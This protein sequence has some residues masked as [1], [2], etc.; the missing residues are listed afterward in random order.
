MRPIDIEVMPQDSAAA[1]DA[2]AQALARLFTDAL[3]AGSPEAAEHLEEDSGSGSGAPAAADEAAAAAVAVAVAEEAV[4][5]A[6]SASNGD[7]DSEEASLARCYRLRA[8]IDQALGGLLGLTYNQASHPMGDPSLCY[9]FNCTSKYSNYSCRVEARPL[10][11]GVVCTSPIRIPEEHR[12]KVAELA[13]RV[14]YRLVMGSIDM[15]FADGE[16]RFRLFHR[17]VSGICDDPRLIA[18]LVTTAITSMDLHFPGIMKV[19]YGGVSP[20]QAL[21]ECVEQMEKASSTPVDHEQ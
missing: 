3:S 21:R 16:V 7:D 12:V 6:V 5:A 18:S 2:L 15:D 20:E 8:S 4:Q 1:P 17:N 11:L 14:N 10:H 9:V 13:T 19:T